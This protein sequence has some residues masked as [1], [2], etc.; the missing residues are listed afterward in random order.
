MKTETVQV[1]RASLASWGG[2]AVHVTLER[3]RDGEPERLELCEGWASGGRDLHRAVQVPGH[4]LAE[5]HALLGAFLE[6]NT[7]EPE[8]E[9]ES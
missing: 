2:R 7:P 4:L 3:D 5:L 6:E 8:P 9:N 1:A